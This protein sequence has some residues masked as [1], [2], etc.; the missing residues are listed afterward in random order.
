MLQPIISALAEQHLSK[1]AE[2]T[3]TDQPQIPADAR[4]V[5]YRNE[6]LYACLQFFAFDKPGAALPFS[7]RLARNCMWTP[8]YAYRVCEE[9]LR[10]L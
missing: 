6:P 4:L 3:E 5:E 10:F 8:D 1:T 9:Y 7:A 2:S